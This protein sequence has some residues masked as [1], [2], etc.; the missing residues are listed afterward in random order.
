MIMKCYV[1]NSGNVSSEIFDN[2]AVIVNFVT[3]KYFGITGSGPDI[4]RMFENPC[5]IELLT[6]RLGIEY[7]AISQDQINNIKDFVNLLVKEDLLISTLEPAQV[8]HEPPAGNR[9]KYADPVLEIYDDLQE[10]I[11]LDPVHDAD[12]E[13]GWPAQQRMIKP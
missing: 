12:P 11:V 1:I 5:S 3:G 7:D 8:S 9:K 4:W 6:E 13:R 2:E 10:L